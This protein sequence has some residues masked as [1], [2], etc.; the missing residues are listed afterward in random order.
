MNNLEQIKKSKS[1]FIK[2]IWYFTQYDNY[3][4]SDK[5]IIDHILTNMIDNGT[6][7]LENNEIDP[8]LENILSLAPSVSDE[9][10]QII[11]NKMMA[12]KTAD[13]ATLSEIW[14]KLSNDDLEGVCDYLDIDIYDL[15][16]DLTIGTP[17]DFEEWAD[18]DLKANGINSNALRWYND[19]P[20]GDFCEICTC[21]LYDN[22]TAYSSYNELIEDIGIDRIKEEIEAL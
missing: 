21:D 1:E 18:E 5:D 4:M 17:S 16:P 22:F 8:D 13:F 20:N 6:I 12:G 2:E 14:E 9:F 7:D 3:Y 10:N 19:I 11:Y 15:D